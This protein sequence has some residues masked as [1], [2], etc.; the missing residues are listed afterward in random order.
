MAIQETVRGSSILTLALTLMYLTGCASTSSQS[1]SVAP[2]DIA[3]PEGFSQLN[4]SE[5]ATL[6]TDKTGI[7]STRDGTPYKVFYAA[8]GNAKGVS[9]DSSD[10]GSWE[11][12]GEQLCV[13]WRQWVKGQRRCFLVGSDGKGRYRAYNKDRMGNAFT[14]VDGNAL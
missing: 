12:R 1:D 8:G 10:S 14:L 6:F 5:M 3:L 2:A 9:G 4:A 7:G 13:Q 11:M